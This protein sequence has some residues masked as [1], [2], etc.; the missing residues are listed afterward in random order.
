MYDRAE[1]RRQVT[2]LLERGVQTLLVAPSVLGKPG[3]DVLRWL[4]T[5][6]PRTI[7][8]AG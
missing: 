2:R 8:E 6:P 3:L 1:A 7:T 4:G 5:A